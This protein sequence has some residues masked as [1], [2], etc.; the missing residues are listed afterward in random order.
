MVP[1]LFFTPYGLVSGNAIPGILFWTLLI[2][3]PNHMIPFLCHK[4][5]QLFDTSLFYS[6]FV[7]IFVD[8]N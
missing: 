7:A 6:T 1:L 8:V 5:T 4:V 3:V 2:R